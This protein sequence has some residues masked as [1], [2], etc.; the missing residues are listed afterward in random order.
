MRTG[1]DVPAGVVLL[2]VFPVSTHTHTH[3]LP[4]LRLK[5]HGIEIPKILGNLQESTD[6]TVLRPYKGLLPN[7]PD[8][9]TTPCSLSSKH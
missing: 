6:N 2:W 1:E 8:A 5:K 4:N 3:P 9:R 7:L